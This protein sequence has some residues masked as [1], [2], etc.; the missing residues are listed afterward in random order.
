MRT[1]TA[2]AERAGQGGALV[3][4]GPARRTDQ[5]RL[6]GLGLA[7]GVALGLPGCV[8]FGEDASAVTVA[9]SWPAAER[10]RIER[11]FEGRVHWVLLGPGDDLS[12]VALRRWPPDVL[13]G[14][15]ASSYRALEHDQALK[16]VLNGQNDGPG[17]RVARRA[18]IGLAVGPRSKARQADSWD[19]PAPLAATDPARITFDDPRRDLVSL[20]WAK[21][22]LAASSWSA[23]YARLV[24]AAGS[25]RRPGR[26][27]GAAVAAVETGEASSAPAVAP[28]DSGDSPRW[29]A[30]FVPQDDKLAWVEGVAV[31]RSTRQ[32]EPARAFLLALEQSRVAER[33]SE[34]ELGEGGTDIEADA[35]LADLLGA[36][37][38][39]AQDELWAAWDAL[40]RA[41]NPERARMWMTAPPPWPPA[42]VSKIL[43]QDLTS[44]TPMLETLAAQVAPEADARDWLVR[45]WIAKG[46]SVDGA[47]LHELAGAVGGRLVREP[48]FRSW[49]R[50]EWTAWARQR[51]RRV[52]RK[53]EGA[54]S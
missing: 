25:A 33:P 45:S 49:L 30:V 9:T 41:G 43:E 8:K 7:L 24:R 46:R 54:V 21:E 14:G 42:S 40:E 1:L 32:P 39:D 16:P 10:D 20:S 6:A 29:P 15:P 34:H 26:I 2:T 36:A 37:L 27:P 4:S 38:V 53:A 51:Y 12:Q 50:G 18:A 28:R 35:L 48:R 23:G 19:D 17:W 47:L 3:T 52:A 31:L 44:T 5:A 13:L 11:L 22:Q